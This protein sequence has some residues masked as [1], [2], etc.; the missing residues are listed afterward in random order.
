[1]YSQADVNRFNN[2]VVR[3]NAAMS[4]GKSRQSEFNSFVSLHNTN[5]DTYNIECAKKYYA[6]DM[7]IARK[8]AGF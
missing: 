5:V 8:L 3:Y 6:D 7:D 2:Q 4:D 1:M